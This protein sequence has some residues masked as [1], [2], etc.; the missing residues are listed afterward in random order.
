MRTL[1]E[2][3]DVRQS[4]PVVYQRVGGLVELP[5]LLREF[6]FDPEQVLAGA[7]VD[8]QALSHVDRKLPY[9]QAT[10][11]LHACARH[12]GHPHFGLL[13]GQRWSLSHVGALGQAMKASPTVGDA[14]E[15]FAAHQHRNSD[16]AAAFLVGQGE[17]ASLGYVVFRKDIDHLELAYDVAMGFAWNILRELCGTGWKATEV[18]F[19]RTQPTDL[20]PYRQ[21][22]RAPLRFDRDH[23]AVRFPK[24]WLDRPVV[25]TDTDRVDVRPVPPVDPADEDLV[26]HA[27]RQLRL[28]LMEGKH[29][30]DHLAK[31]LSVHRRTL[32]RRLKDHGTTFQRVL[33]EVRYE[34]A[35]QLL[36][37]T[38]MPIPDIAAALCYSEVSAFTHAFRRWTGTS[39]HR[40]RSGLRPP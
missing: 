36:A 29:S 6:G 22:F 21:H 31:R 19:A 13:A 34:V 30:G 1:A 11:L 35:R 40:W 18:I 38:R 37:N 8:A 10:R 12:T 26:H 27:Y 17:S 14:L 15:T 5:A 39:P 33:D 24:R 28:L 16:A 9:A 32:N 23:C 25:T 7:G 2:Q 4:H 20:L 3:G